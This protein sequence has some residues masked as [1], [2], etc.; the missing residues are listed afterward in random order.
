[1]SVDTP[2]PAVPAARRELRAEHLIAIVAVL[3]VIF[4]IGAH[5]TSLPQ[6]KPV[7]TTCA[8]HGPRLV[9]SGGVINTGMA[10]AQFSVIAS[11]QIAGR[12]AHPVRRGTTVDLGAFSAGR[13]TATYTYA[14]KGLLGTAITACT[15]RVS[16]VPPP[17]G[18]D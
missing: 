12:R 17:S 8:W 5:A 13:W 9:M 10:T 15:A 3:L 2:A 1:M 4:A 6:G 18:E 16:T 7:G 14:R 11:V